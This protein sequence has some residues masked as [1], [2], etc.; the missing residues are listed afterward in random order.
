MYTH[1][2]LF[3][4]GECC[5]FAGAAR[6]PFLHCVDAGNRGGDRITYA[7]SA[8][9]APTLS[10]MCAGA[11]YEVVAR[12]K[13]LGMAAYVGIDLHRL[14]SLVV[15]IDEEGERHQRTP[16]SVLHQRHRHVPTHPRRPRTR[17]LT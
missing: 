13:A 1:G 11:T 9:R 15:C 5:G 12:A 17:P 2:L 8:D 14:R 4:V 7:L 3:V 16:P 10:V 6:V